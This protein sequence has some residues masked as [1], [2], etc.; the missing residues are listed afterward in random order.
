[1]LSQHTA[2]TCPTLQH[3][4]D[5]GSPL[6]TSQKQTSAANLLCCVLETIMLLVASLWKAQ[7]S[8]PFCET[9]YTTLMVKPAAK[10]RVVTLQSPLTLPTAWVCH[11]MVQKPLP[12][13][14]RRSSSR[15]TSTACLLTLVLCRQTTTCS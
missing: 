14:S 3:T 13:L 2:L 9:P 12:L 11:A 8:I 6:L 4:E 7:F 15:V 5:V 10:L 1:M